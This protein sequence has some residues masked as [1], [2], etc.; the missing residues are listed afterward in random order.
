MNVVHLIGNIGADF[1]VKAVGESHVANLRLA[2]TDYYGGEEHTEWHNIVIWGNDAVNA[3]K[4]LGKGSKILVTGSLQTR[5]WEDKDGNT[6]YTT[7]IRAHRVEYLTP[8]GASATTAAAE[9][10]TNGTTKGR[11]GRRAKG[12]DDFPVSA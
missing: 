1:E 3:G 7:E 11:R 5:Q 9:P 6:R 2:T 8:K 4:F 12:G 10:T